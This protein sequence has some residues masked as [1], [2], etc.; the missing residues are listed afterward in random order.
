ME[1]AMLVLMLKKQKMSSVHPFESLSKQQMCVRLFEVKG[2]LVGLFVSTK[3][4]V[5]RFSS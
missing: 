1:C 5:F 2:R 3:A 4:P